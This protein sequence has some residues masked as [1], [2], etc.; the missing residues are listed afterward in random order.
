MLES[1]KNSLRF[2]LYANASFLCERLLAQID[3]EEV[4]LLLAESYLGESKPYKAYDVLK[5][6]TSPANRYKLA[7]TCMKLDRPNEAE[8][9]L[10]D[11]A[12]NRTFGLMDQDNLKKVPNGAAGLFLLGQVRE[13]QQKTKDAI[14]AYVKALKMDPTLWCAFERLC[15][16]STDDIDPSKF[17]TKDHPHILSLN[18]A[19][20]E[21]GIARQQANA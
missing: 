20:Q 18:S 6:C 13:L 16:L 8:K 17:F 4:R 11:P 3:N 2:E 14:R 12:H 21:E 1:V 9:F 7:L 15:A 10:L 5:P 19:I